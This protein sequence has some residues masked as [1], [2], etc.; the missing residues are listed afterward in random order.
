M[1]RLIDRVSADNRLENYRKYEV[2]TNHHFAKFLPLFLVSLMA[3]GSVNA[4]DLPKIP[5]ELLGDEHVREEFGVNDFTTPS[6]RKVFEHLEV[7]GKMPFDEVRRDISKK[8]PADRS[9]VALG[10]GILI[11]DGFLIIHSEKLDEL[12]EV[13]RALSKYAETLGAGRRVKVHTGKI[14]ELSL[15]QDWDKLKEELAKTQADVEAEMV[16]LRDVD[17][18]HMIALGGWLRAF[19]IAIKATAKDYSEEKAKQL[20]AGSEV[21]GYFLMS[22]ETLHPKMQEEAYVQELHKG[23]SSLRSALE[24]PE[25]TV[26]TKEQVAGFQPISK[27]LVDVVVKRLPK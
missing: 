25:G 10:L 8:T 3:F 15:L 9:L 27:W 20:V 5:E 22:L 16:L 11:A 4:D 1:L 18:A 7:L 12:E 2:M 6:I 21:V 14:L 19:E 26:L 17:I 24:L 23:L 13:G